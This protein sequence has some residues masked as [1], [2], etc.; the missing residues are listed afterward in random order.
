MLWII[1]AIALGLA[2]LNLLPKQRGITLLNV[3]VILLALVAIAQSYG[4]K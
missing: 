3:A 1:A 4:I 2:I